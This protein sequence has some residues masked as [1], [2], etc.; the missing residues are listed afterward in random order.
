MRW[1]PGLLWDWVRQ[2]PKPK[3]G[4][5]TL[6]RVCSIFSQILKLI[7]RLEF[8]AAVKKHQAERHARG[9]SSWAQMIAMMF[10]QLG[11]ASSLREITGGLAA[12]EGK[13]R[14]LG[15]AEPPKRSTLSYANEHRPWQLYQTVFETLLERCQGEAKGHKRK[16]RFRHKLLS[17]DSTVIPLCLATF[18]WAHYKRAKG[19]VKLH[20]VLD[21]DGYLPS[22]AVMTE[23]KTADI[24]VAKGM[25]FA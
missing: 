4:D 3:T 2:E 19:A 9:F 22:F 8:E 24:T 12:C 6:N 21:H 5:S 15:V 1:S 11:H 14:H 18:D 25:S 13:L 10:C 16:F 20:M 17:L 23:G 7:P